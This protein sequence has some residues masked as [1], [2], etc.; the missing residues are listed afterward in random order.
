[1]ELICPKVHLKQAN[2]HRLIPSRY[3]PAGIFDLLVSKEDLEDLMD[4]ES[5]TNDRISAEFGQLHKI[6]QE[7]WI[8]NVPNASVVMASFC[9]PAPQGGRFNTNKV[10]AWYAAFELET[11]LK[12]VMYH[13]RQ[14]FLEVGKTD[15]YVQMREYL[16]DVDH[17]FHDVRQPKEN[18]KDIY[19]PKSY[20]KS[21]EFSEALRGIGSNGLVYKSIRYDKGQC[22]AV[23]KPRCVL[24]VRQASHYEL[25]WSGNSEAEVL[26]I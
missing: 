17:D 1:M 2:T 12:E 14:E 23:F 24:N 5:W 22:I 8:M 11:A 7:E 3:P 4:L 6:P 21:Q 15:G 13:R 25:R 19:N 20:A 9:H 10:G 18:Y 16:S 26:K